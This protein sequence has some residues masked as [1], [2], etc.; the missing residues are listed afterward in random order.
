MIPL[1]NTFLKQVRCAIICSQ[2]H[3]TTTDEDGPDKDKEAILYGK[4]MECLE[5]GYVRFNMIYGEE[6]EKRKLQDVCKGW[7]TIDKLNEDQWNLIKNSFPEE[8]SRVELN[9]I[10]ADFKAKQSDCRNT[11][12]P[13]YKRLRTHLI[14]GNYNDAE[15][16]MT[17][18]RNIVESKISNNHAK[19]LSNFGNSEQNKN[20]RKTPEGNIKYLE[21]ELEQKNKWVEF[22]GN[23]KKEWQSSDIVG[24][25]WLTFILLGAPGIGNSAVTVVVGG[26]NIN[27]ATGKTKRGRNSLKEI[28]EGR[29]GLNEPGE[30]PYKLSRRTET[31]ENTGANDH[32]AE[33]LYLKRKELEI[34]AAKLS[35]SGRQEKLR[36][37][38]A[39]KEFLMESGQMDTPNYRICI[40]ELNDFFVEALNRRQVSITIDSSYKQESQSVSSSLSSSSSS[41]SLSSSSSS[42]IGQSSEQNYLDLDVNL[43]DF[44]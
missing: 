7:Y 6:I 31:N 1:S 34:K 42:N 16:L 2:G 17:M 22:Y 40:N 37:L 29:D 24:H 18:R 13:Q 30:R 15:I 4:V 41:S 9:E 19:S 27:K 35:D 14:S 12:G 28:G 36:N 33:A 39:Y 5:A 38:K 23:K 20:L 26:G 21:N 44:E 10:W 25:A 43:S 8:P 11:W 3:G 32:A